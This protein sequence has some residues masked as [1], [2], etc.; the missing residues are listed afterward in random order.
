MINFLEK[1]AVCAVYGLFWA[2]L[3]GLVYLTMN[4]LG[5]VWIF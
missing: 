2:V 1:I 4:K 5:I 3:G